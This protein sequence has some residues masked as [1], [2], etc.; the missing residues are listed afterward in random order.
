MA[1][2][3][4]VDD[5]AARFEARTDDLVEILAFENGKVKAEARFEVAIV[6]S[7]L[8]FYA[9]LALTDFGRPM[10]TKSRASQEASI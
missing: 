9:A 8:R 2:Q 10:E 5:M 4:R 1:L 6:P 3:L 7:K